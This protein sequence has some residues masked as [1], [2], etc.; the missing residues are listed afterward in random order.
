MTLFEK[1]PEGSL[2][3]QDLVNLDLIKRMLVVA[4]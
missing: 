1:Q 3:W 2:K 4:E